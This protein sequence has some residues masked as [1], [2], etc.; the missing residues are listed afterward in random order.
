LDDFNF[1][2]KKGIAESTKV[3]RTAIET[4]S[5]KII[6]K[7]RILCEPFMT[8]RNL[9]P[10]LSRHNNRTKDLANIMNFLQYAD[11]K[12]DLCDISVLININKKKT[13]KLFNKLKKSNLISS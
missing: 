3:V 5:A 13:L 12:N 10:T 8:R 2:T 7:N 1:V 6:P 9:Y 4:L 11:G